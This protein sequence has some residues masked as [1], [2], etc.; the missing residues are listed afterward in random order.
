MNLTD[1]LLFRGTY[2]IWTQ[3]KGCAILSVTA[4]AITIHMPLGIVAWLIGAAISKL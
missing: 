3:C 1:L 2:R 4:T